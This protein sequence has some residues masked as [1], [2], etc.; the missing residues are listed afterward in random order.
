MSGAK[1]ALADLLKALNQCAVAGMDDLPSIIPTAAGTLVREVDRWIVHK[2]AETPIVSTVHHPL[3]HE[4]LWRT[5]D[6]HVGHM[7]QLPA[8]VQS[9]ARALMR[10]HDMEESRAIATA[11]NAIRAWAAGHAF[12]GKVE[13]TPEVRQA[14]R[15]ALAEWDRLKASHK[16]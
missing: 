12:G 14:A 8:Y 13:T 3:G 16:D 4:G 11:I 10:D 2:S 1:G 7:Q 5:P 15:R 9:T 6:K